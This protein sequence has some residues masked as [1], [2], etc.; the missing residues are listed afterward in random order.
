M[1]GPVKAEQ[2]E[3]LPVSMDPQRD[4]AMTISVNPMTRVYGLTPDTTCHDCAHL[5]QGSRGRKFMKCD[6]RKITHGA[7]TDHRVRW[8]ACGLWEKRP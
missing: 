7:A 8:P 4:M 2:D 3:L 5:V 1:A 6:R